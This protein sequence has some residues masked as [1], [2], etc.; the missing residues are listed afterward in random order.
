MVRLRGQ[1]GSSEKR[2]H[3]KKTETSAAEER[4]EAI[5]T[6][7]S[8]RCNDRARTQRG[9]DEPADQV[10]AD[11]VEQRGLAAGGGSAS[12]DLGAR[13]QDERERDPEGAVGREGGGTEGLR[14]Q[15]RPR[16]NDARCPQ[17]TPTCPRAAEPDRRSRKQCR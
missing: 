13:P 11:G 15:P 16:A 3:K 1:R 4:S 14:D 17:R 9:E 8:D 2:A 5:S 7:T 6:A 10:E 12:L